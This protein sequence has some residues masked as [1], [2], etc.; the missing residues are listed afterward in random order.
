MFKTFLMNLLHFSVVMSIAVVTVI[1]A[2]LIGTWHLL[3]LIPY[4]TILGA[5][6][7]TLV[8]YDFRKSNQDF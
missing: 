4:L 2:F 8:E 1:L 6:M 7:L 5:G 3:L